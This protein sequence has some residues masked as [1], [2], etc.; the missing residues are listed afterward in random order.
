MVKMKL[1]LAVLLVTSVFTVP[2]LASDA[3]VDSAARI[4]QRLGARVGYA[5]IDVSRNVTWLH[6]ADQ[7]FPMAST[8]KVLACAALLSSGIPD[9]PTSLVDTLES[10]S[11]ATEAL[12]G[13]SVSPY[14]LC[15]MTMRTSDNTAANLVLEALGGPDAVTRFMRSIGDETTRLDRTEPE[16]NTGT[17][18][19]DRDTTTP[20][21]MA[22]SFSKLA[23][24]D[25]LS[26]AG[27]DQ[28]I[29][30]LRS[31]EVAEPL[32]RATI[33]EDWMIADRSGAGGFG[34]R[35]IVAALWPNPD[36]PVVVAFYLT[37]TTASL[38]ERNAAIAEFGSV[39]ADILQ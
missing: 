35:G 37:E 23:I 21:A 28:L 15:E 24:G 31:N 2:T 9:E 3:L 18:G 36:R 11:P 38:D 6:N 30:W 20:R 26:D 5:V 8:F 13:Q 34:T 19:D 33:P 27:R 1:L 29:G 32:L 4:E 22:E 17:P 16:L 14:R 12:V 25:A 10:Y 39:L 7:R